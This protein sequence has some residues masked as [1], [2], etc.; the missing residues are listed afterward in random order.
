MIVQPNERNMYDQRWIE[1]NLFERHG[2]KLL[3]KTLAEM[4]T[5]SVLNADQGLFIGQ[6]EVA[7]VY[8]RAGYTPQDYPSEHEWSARLKIEK[9]TAIKCPNINYHI[10]GAKKVQQV[11]ANQGVLEQYVSDPEE[12]ALLRSCFSGLY[13]LDNTPLGLKAYDMAMATPERFVMKPQ[14]EGGGN[15]IYGKD[16]PPYLSKLTPNQRN[17]YILMDLIQTP[18]HD[19]LMVKGGQIHSASVIS[20]LGIY[21]L[22]LSQGDCVYMNEEAGYLVRT[23]SVGT[24]EGGVAT[25]YSVLDSLRLT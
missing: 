8:F 16:I 25:G 4:H 18:P 14:R 24:N 15:N 6:D 22:W 5:E 11:L 21:G 7:I 2:I 20:E 1:F 3:R 10:V 9:S 13:P 12:A 19:G 17:A 23:K